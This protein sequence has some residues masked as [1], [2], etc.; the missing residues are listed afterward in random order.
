MRARMRQMY[1]FAVVAV[2]LVVVVGGS[3]I[4]QSSNFSVGTW[5]LNVAK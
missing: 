3:A 2:A 1:L 5:K 4:A